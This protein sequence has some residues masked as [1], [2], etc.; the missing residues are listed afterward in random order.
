MSEVMLDLFGEQDIFKTAKERYG[1]WPLTVWDINFS[2]KLMQAMKKK[3]GDD[4]NRVA[5][6]KMGYGSRRNLNPLQR[7]GKN[8]CYGVKGTTFHISVFNPVVAMYLLNCYAP[9]EGICFDPFAGG[10]ARAIVVA[11]YGLDYVGCEVRQEEV[12]AVNR[13]VKNN[14]KSSNVIIHHIDARLATSV[15]PTDYADFLI[16]C[17]PYWNLEMYDG[18]DG[19][20]SML[21]SYEDFCIELEKCVIETTKILKSGA[22]SCWVVGLHRDDKGNLLC[23][24]HDVVAMHKRNGFRH[25]EEIVLSHKNNGAI[26]RVG[27]FDKGN[28]FLIRT[29]E[30]ALVFVKE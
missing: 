8:S 19:D 10:G 6:P 26:R 3:I 11:S 14:G 12:D 15:I 17:P 23:L 13:R 30:Y 28:R 22:V 21:D 29:H 4:S 1:V 2:D 20:L 27:A 9:K 25:K 24:N 18:G 16:T 7:T 5:N